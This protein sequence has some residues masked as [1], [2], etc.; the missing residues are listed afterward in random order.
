MAVLCRQIERCWDV[1]SGVIRTP[2][3]TSHMA[4]D[5]SISIILA[6]DWLGLVTTK[7]PDADCQDWD[8]DKSLQ[9][10]RWSHSWVSPMWGLSGITWSS[11]L[12]LSDTSWPVPA[13]SD[14]LTRLEGGAVMKGVIGALRFRLIYSFWH[15]WQFKSV[16]FL[17]IGLNFKR[18]NRLKINFSS[19]GLF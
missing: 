18:H 14:Q 15:D 6:S 8:R 19:V 17:T 10:R 1:D 9:P 3:L 11:S 5:W 4:S 13:T 12:A 7:W 2:G 16:Q